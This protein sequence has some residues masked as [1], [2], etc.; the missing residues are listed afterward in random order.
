[1]GAGLW[2][3]V[4]VSR[5]MA[6]ALRILTTAYTAAFLGYVKIGNDL[7]EYLLHDSSRF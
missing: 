3:V 5:E 6:A 1:M 7:E 4:E 2:L